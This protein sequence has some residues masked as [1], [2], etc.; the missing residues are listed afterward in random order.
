[1]I[2]GSFPLR[3][4]LGGSPNRVVTGHYTL[5]LRRTGFRL[6]SLLVLRKDIKFNFISHFV[7]EVGKKPTR[8]IDAS[9]SVDN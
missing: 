4:S 8:S 1:M 2:G 5:S 9:L 6:S 3:D 7:A